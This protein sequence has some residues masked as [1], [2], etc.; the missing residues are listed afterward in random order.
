M[1][2]QSEADAK[3]KS[4]TGTDTLGAWDMAKYP[5]FRSAM[6]TLGNT[7]AD[8]VAQDPAARQVLADL[9]AQTPAYNAHK[10]ADMNNQQ[11][12]LGKF[13][14]GVDAALQAKTLADP[15]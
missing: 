3:D 6:D 8:R 9:A 12:D 7:L 1:P 15:D 10:P 4:N 13:L 11:R 2:V 5:E 14:D